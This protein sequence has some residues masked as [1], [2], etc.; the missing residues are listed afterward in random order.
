MESA[1]TG[2]R[3]DYSLLREFYKRAAQSGDGVVTWIA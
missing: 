2:L 3:R 1:W